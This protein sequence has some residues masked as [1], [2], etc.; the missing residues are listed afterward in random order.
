MK[1]GRAC[2]EKSGKLQKLKG[3]E[4]QGEE[5]GHNKVGEKE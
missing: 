1:A 2:H 3:L 5:K 4:F